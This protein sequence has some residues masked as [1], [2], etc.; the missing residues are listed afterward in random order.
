MSTTID[1]LDIQISTSVGQSP[2]KIQELATALGE[3]KNQ[4]KIGAATSAM[5]SLAKALDVLNPALNALNPAKLQQ[6]RAAMSGLSGIQ[7]ASGLSSSINSLKKIPEVISNLD[8][9]DLAKFERQ[10]ERLS[11]ALGPLAQRLDKVGTAFSKLPTQIRKVVT[12]TNQAA[13]ATEKAAVADKKHG[14]AINAKS[15]N[16]MSMIHN[17]NAVLQATNFVVSGITA[18]LAQAMEWDGIQ[19]R[20][21]RAFGEDAEEV[22]AYAQKINDVLGI[23]IQQFMQYSSLYGSLLSGFGMAQEKVTTISVGLTE[24][25]YDIWAAYNDR[26]K[27]LEDASEAVRSAITGE[28]EPIRN[29]G[30]ALTEASLQEYLE[31]VGMA[32]VSIEKLSEAQ[33]AE[34]RYAAMMNAAL[35]Q[36]IVGTYAAEMQTAEGAVRNLSQAFKGLVQA[37]GSLFIPILQAV[38][39]YLTAFVELLYEAIAAI[40]DF[41]GIAF[42]EIDWGNGVGD[43]ASGMEDAAAGADKLGAGLGGA[44]KSAK[45]IKD[46][47]MGFDELNVIKPPDENAN[48]GNAAGSSGANWGDGLDLKTMWD[49]SVFAKA[50]KQVDEIKEKLKPI[51]TT[52]G[53]IAAGIAAWKIGSAFLTALDTVKLA[54]KVI[55]GQKGTMGMTGAGSALTLLTSPKT[56]TMVEK[57]GEILRKTP[58]GSL[59]LGTGSTSVGAA[60]LAV[61]GVVAAIASL[62]GGIVLVYKESENF[63]GGLAAIGEGIAWVF[64]QVGNLVSWCGEKIAEFGG[65]VKEK[66]TGIIPEGILDFFEGLDLGIG[67]LLITAGGL[68][69]FGPWGLAIE[70]VVLAIKGIGYATK[71]ALPEI[72]L[73]GEGVSKATKEKVEPFLQKMDNL[74]TTL[75]T[76]DWSNAI[77]SEED[78][79]NISTKLGE[80]TTVIVN[81]L[82]ADKNK[83]LAKVNP[84]KGALSEEKYEELLGKIEES[85]S[86][87]VKTVKDGEAQINKILKKASEESRALT[88][89][90]AKEIAKIQEGMKETGIKYLSESETESNLILKRLKD[91]AT[92]LTAE[93]ASNVIKN[94]IEARDK[95]IAAAEEQYKGI[96]LE[97]QRLLDTGVINE[98]EYAEIVKAAETTRD[99]TV[100][101]AKTQY[102]DILTTAQTKMGEYSKYIDEETGEIKSNW[103]VF[104]DDVSKKWNEAWGSIKKWWDDNMAKFFTKKHWEEVFASVL[105]GIATKMDEVKKDWET[106]WNAVKKWW[107]DNMAK[108][109]TKKYWQDKIDGVKSG[110]SAKMTDMKKS[111]EDTWNNVNVWWNNNIAKYFTKDYWAG[112]IDGLKSGVESKLN[113]A[114][115]KVE[116]FFNVDTWKEKVLAAI[117]AIKDNFKMPTLPKIKLEVTYDTSIT[118]WKKTVA[119]ALGLGGWPSL[120]WSTYATGGWPEVGEAFIARENGPELV[121]RIGGRTAVANNDQIVEAVARGVYDAVAAAMGAYSGGSDQA[122]NIYLDG[123]Q[124]TAAVEKR[125]KER[126]ATLMTGGMA[127]GY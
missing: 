122:I 83:A 16:L 58:I 42:F 88:D 81:E 25:S 54:L 47:T 117:Q 69:L 72:D 14:E 82:D 1:S 121:G 33:K 27:T 91:N 38:V 23:N 80:I 93:Q 39:P 107:D 114:W 75:S 103:K 85:Y 45:K 68:A 74:E 95:T 46:Y 9:A 6:L 52:V 44:A 32:K 118:G 24:L 60:A 124:I 48:S 43:M 71:D 20:F 119:D 66:L 127:Y 110:V 35:N 19:Y 50:S 15:L 61:V 11:T 108:Y 29:A 37:L 7:K 92:Q 87:Q 28:I 41:F 101:A 51:L 30:I 56:T 106:K 76:L 4:G 64:E 94:A 104:C 84:L 67:D 65:F 22:Y 3:L 62:V 63:R 100:S 18:T 5:K 102:N 115:A 10:M 90:E 8:T 98:T 55:A 126:G 31:Q 34:V 59:I 49:D 109:F 73:F 105:L 125:Q 120:K 40:A 112:K 2:Q 89:E 116:A 96:L 36:G 79:T 97:A 57:L 13:T 12:L 21:G 78:L 17:F 53:L 113:E 26:F 77:V 86:G 99:E 123:K 70:G 111:W